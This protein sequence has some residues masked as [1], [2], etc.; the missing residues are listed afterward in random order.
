MRRKNR[1]LSIIVAVILSVS[2]LGF[3]ACSKPDGG[4]GGRDKV[5]DP[6][7]TQIQVHTYLAGFK[8]EWLYALEDSFE[9]E[10]ENTV[11]EEGKKGVQVW[12]TGEMKKFSSDDVKNGEV[13]VY[14]MEGADY[15]AI[16]NGNA[17][18]DLTPVVTETSKYENKT[19]ASKMTEEQ[20]KF[21]GGVTAEGQTA[22]YYGV[23]HYKGAVGLIYNV[24]LFDSK[25]YYISDSETLSLISSSNPNRSKG[26]DGKTGVIGGVDYSLD[27]G[28][29][30]TYK[31]FLFLCSEIVKRGD[32]PLCWTGSFASYYLNLLYA[33]LVVEYEGAEQSKLGL[34][35]DGT[36]ENLVVM[37]NGEPVINEDGTV[38]TESL[39]ITVENGYEV[40]RQAGR[41]YALDLIKKL[42]NNKKYYN[43][44][45]FEPSY[46]QLMAE[47]DFLKSGT[48]MSS[49]SK[50]YAMLVDGSWWESEATVYFTEMAK[51]D[52]KY[53]KQNRKFGW[54]P[55]PK[56]TEN[57]VGETSV[58][59]DYEDSVICVKAGLAEGKKKAALDLVQYACADRS[60][61]EFTVTT[62]ALKAFDYT[63]DENSEE[64]KKLSPF[65]KSLIEYSQTSDYFF[66][67][68]N[69]SFYLKHRG[70]LLCTT[71]NTNG[72]F[73]TP[74]DAFT[75]PKDAMSAK[76]FFKSSY[77][78]WKGRN[79]D[80]FTYWERVK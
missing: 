78:Y 37:K 48:D 22:K 16:K 17:L 25:G 32:T 72:D 14:F 61:T 2:A 76:A 52:A 36:A 10:N 68:S 40:F 15:Y 3:T 31:E 6:T 8:D 34:T 23:P 19:I 77:E 29:P 74:I 39:E 38:E 71:V 65:A 4:K 30:A 64:Y 9:K 50:A 21:F 58:F 33:A 27:D 5:L 62:G 46:S 41:Y 75:D 63:I 73:A 47:R 53:S 79:T 57:E 11:Y 49:D 44:K 12:H 55:L 24:E 20:R 59:Y 45:A 54:M 1:L 80:K 70:E 35:F 67:N 69:D 66:A 51:K 42:L 7:K 13:D 28:L 56:A 18:E 60:L 43:D 26:P